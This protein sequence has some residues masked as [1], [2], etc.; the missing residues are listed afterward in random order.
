MEV[1]QLKVI[2]NIQYCGIITWCYV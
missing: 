1:I 2:D